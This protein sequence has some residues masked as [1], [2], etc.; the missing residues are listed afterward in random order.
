MRTTWS[1]VVTGW[2]ISHL[3]IAITTIPG[4]LVNQPNLAIPAGPPLKVATHQMLFSAARQIHEEKTQL[5]CESI[6]G[7][8]ASRKV[9]NKH[10][11]KSIPK[12]MNLGV[13]EHMKEES[14]LV[15]GIG[16][17]TIRNEY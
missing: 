4:T 6:T 9:P 11:W 8:K 12:Q 3:T 5:P 13:Q 15:V 7:P 16:E 2:L 10:I 1:P 17:T 14:S